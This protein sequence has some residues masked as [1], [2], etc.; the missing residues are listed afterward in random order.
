M[1]HEH[2]CDHLENLENIPILAQHFTETVYREG[3][4]KVNGPFD[5]A[6]DPL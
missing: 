5:I 4:M 6:I 2:F 3:P 1:V